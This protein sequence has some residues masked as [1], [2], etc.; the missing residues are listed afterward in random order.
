MCSAARAPSTTTSAS[1]ETFSGVLPPPETWK[2]PELTVRPEV[3]V[4]LLIEAWA[5][6]APVPSRVPD[7]GRV[8]GAPRDAIATP[9]EKENET[10][11]LP[12]EQV[13]FSVSVGLVSL[14]FDDAMSTERAAIEKVSDVEPSWARATP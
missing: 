3:I 10:G 12:L 7:S 8:V 13:M 2:T 5:V 9:V 1:A 4:K 14:T 6:N 11:Q